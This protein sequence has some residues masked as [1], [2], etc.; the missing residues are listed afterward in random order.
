MKD[1]DT[2]RKIICALLLCP[3]DLVDDDFD[4]DNGGDDNEAVWA[5]ASFRDD[6]KPARRVA[7]MILNVD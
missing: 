6:R 3:L 5:S 1:V 2:K 4:E 7:A